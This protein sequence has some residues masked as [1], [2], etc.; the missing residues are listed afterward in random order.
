MGRITTAACAKS[1]YSD[2]TYVGME[3]AAPAII[4]GWAP[5][6]ATR[7]EIEVYRKDKTWRTPPSYRCAGCGE[8]RLSMWLSFDAVTVKRTFSG[9]AIGR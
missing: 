1:Q 6:D 5:L 4:G 9:R 8:L 7:V 3:T 2:M